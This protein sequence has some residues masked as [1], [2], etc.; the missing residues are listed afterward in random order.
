MKE[1]L[2]LVGL[3]AGVVLPLWN[4]PLI[5]KIRR[6]RSSQDISLSWTFGVFACLVLMLPSA[7]L[8][9]DFVFKTFALV[10]LV[11]FGAVV[12]EVVRYR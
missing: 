4:I 11:L 10:N 7:L 2:R 8:S 12:L 3:I 9:S 1:A 5:L 6:R